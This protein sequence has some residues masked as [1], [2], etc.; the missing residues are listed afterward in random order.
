VERHLI[1]LG[2]PLTILRPVM[3][4]DIFQ[5]MGP[6]LVDGELVLKMWLRPEVAVQLIATSDIGLFA[7]DAFDEPA[8]WLGRQVEIAGDELTGPGIAAA[9]QHASGIPSR[10]EPQPIEALRAARGDLAAM[11]D[12]FDRAGYQADLPALHRL[13]PGLVSLESWLRGN[14]TVPLATVSPG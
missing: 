14:W 7:A 1:R 5:E 3:F 11:F 8:A 6:R 10:Y 13:R 4:H 2:L 9:F 12:W